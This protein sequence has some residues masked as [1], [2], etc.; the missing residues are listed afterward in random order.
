M[1]NRDKMERETER[2]ETWRY[3]VEGI[4][5]VDNNDPGDKSGTVRL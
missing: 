1:W 5:E 2:V 3:G 4:E